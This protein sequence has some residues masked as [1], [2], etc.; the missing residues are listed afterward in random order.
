[1]KVLTKI[2]REAREIVR[3]EPA[4]TKREKPTWKVLE[5]RG[6]RAQVLGVP[7]GGHLQGRDEDGEAFHPETNILMNKGDVVPLTYYHGY[8]PDDPFVEQ[9][10]PE[11]V[12]LAK[13]TGTGPEGYQFEALVDPGTPLGTRVIQALEAGVEVRA[14]SGAIAHMV[15]YGKAGLIDHWPVAEMAVFDTNDWRQP[16]NKLATV[17]PKR[18]D[19]QDG[20]LFIPEPEAL[21][22]GAEALEEGKGTEIKSQP[23]EKTSEENNMSDPIVNLEAVK[24]AVRAEIQE[25]LKA[26]PAVTP[27]GERKAPAVVKELGDPDPKAA[28][29]HYLRTGET[30]NMKLT[31]TVNANGGFLVPPDYYLNIIAKRDELSIARKMGAVQF[32]TDRNIFNIP[33]EN[34]SMTEFSI[35]AE[36]GAISGAANEPTFSQKAI[37]VYKM[38]K[39]IKVTEELMDDENSGLE[40][41][42][43]EAIGRAWAQTENRYTLIGTG[44]GQ[45]E[46]ILQG[47]TATANLAGTAAITP[48]E[49][50]R[51]KY[52]LPQPYRDDA[53]A[54]VM[55]GETEAYLRGLQGSDFLFQNTPVASGLRN[56]ESMMGFP[57]LTSRHMP[58]L[59]AVS[60]KVL[61]FANFRYYAMVSNRGLRVRR[62]NELYAGTGEI[63]ILADIRWGAGVLQAEA[64][65]YSS[66]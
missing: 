41:F 5:D 40:A 23:L 52:A 65:R 66:T 2:K 49:V 13:Y 58:I 19:P 57:V 46:G 3:V 59:G 24:E 35:V 14:S 10:P 20:G 56:M 4:D 60:R 45:P 15:R 61:A 1:M 22:K 34:V 27:A 43:A 36:G 50:N 17:T 31:S 38:S 7:F 51:L 28:F 53:A 6:Y 42:L 9:N 21:T 54:W 62:L 18:E 16:A 8:G 12:G 32:T 25:A 33:L 63:G 30:K 39:L 37:T 64:I 47:G 26:A 55:A 44:S 11:I 29:L 48:A